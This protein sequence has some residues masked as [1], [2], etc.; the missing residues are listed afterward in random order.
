MNPSDAAKLTAGILLF[1]CPAAAQDSADRGLLDAEQARE[2][3]VPTLLAALSQGDARA[4]IVAARAIGRLENPAYRDALVPLLD[5][6]DP[7][8][9]RAAAGA[10]AQMRASF[11]WAAVIKAERDASVRA[12]IF[13][14]AGRAKPPADDAELLL[15]AGLKDADADARAGA[16]RGLESLFRLNSKPPRQAAAA[17]LAAL[18]QAFAANRTEEIREL[19]LLTMRA[20]RDRDSTTLATALA[21]VS[22]QVRRIAVIETRTWVEDSSPLVRY[23]ALHVAPSCDRVV[24]AVSDASEHVALE[25]V[26][27]LGNLKC[28]AALLTPL[29]SSERSWRIRAHALVALATVDPARARDRITAMALDPTWQMR[30]YVAKAARIV[31]NSAVLARLARDENPNVC[32]AAMTTADDAVRALGSEH[33]G[34]IRAG[35]E[36]LKNTPGLK[37]RLPQ[38]V[39][40]FHRL[41]ASGIMTVRDPRIAVLTRIGEIEGT[42]N[43]LREA[44][45]D[46]DPAVA[47]LAARVLTIRLG[48]AVAPQTTRLPVPNI[49]P[50]EYISGL[51]AATARITMRGLGTITVDLLTDEAPVTVAV[52]CKLAEAG[53]YNGLT[54]HRIVPNFVIQGGVRAP[55]NM[56]DARASSCAM[57]W[58]SRATPA[59]ASEFR[60]AAGTRETHR[61]TSTWSIIS[62]SSAITP[63]LR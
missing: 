3:G 44:L 28:D 16:A 42:D 48:K 24:V 18:H 8:V 35:A 63:C 39:A 37:D 58:A 25:A 33:S 22:P 61:S 27:L 60:P 38:L 43:L 29:V 10:L 21:D 46:R 9:R 47:A 49:P 55:M 4:R 17:T 15:A 57:N 40:A 30:T 20:A 11:A 59:A 41:T 31:N 62:A 53:Q 13:E 52:F 23:E 32:V 36:R 51:A 5:S 26:D 1:L 2:A 12:A 54:F 56:M 19:I 14:A 50:A 7:R 34:L 45:H 6:S